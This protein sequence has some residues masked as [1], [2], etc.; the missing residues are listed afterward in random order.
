[1]FTRYGAVNQVLGNLIDNSRYWLNDVR[2]H[3]RK[4]RI[5]VDSQKRTL[6]FADSGPNIDDTIRPYLFEP[7]YSLRV[8]QSGLGLY[9]C[10]YYMR[11]MKGDIYETNE[12]NRQTDMPGAQFTLDFSRVPDV[13]SEL[14]EHD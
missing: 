14:E 2:I 5:E 8:P 9:I 4:I 12:N 6:C 11:A 1:V 13:V 7:G 10:K 3:N